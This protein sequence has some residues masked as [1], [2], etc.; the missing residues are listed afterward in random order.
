MAPD[1]NM[2][3]GLICLHY[4]PPSHQYIP[5]HHHMITTT[6]FFFFSFFKLVQNDE[7]TGGLASP[8]PPSSIF[9]LVSPP[10]IP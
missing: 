9:G 8:S 4:L 2:F 7:K 3:H 5:H 1:P 10:G 6:L